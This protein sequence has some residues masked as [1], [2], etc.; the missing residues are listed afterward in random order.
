MYVCVIVIIIII[1]ISIIII[2][3]AIVI[4]FKLLRTIFPQQPYKSITGNCQAIL[5]R[6]PLGEDIFPPSVGPQKNH[7]PICS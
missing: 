7:P 3:I 6:P 5:F 1:I 2:I 4:V